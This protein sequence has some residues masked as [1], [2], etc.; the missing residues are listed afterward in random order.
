MSSIYIDCPFEVKYIKIVLS[1]I[2]IPLSYMKQIKVQ[3]VK[4][5]QDLKEGTWQTF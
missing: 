4:V 1:F 2:C 3:A 5:R